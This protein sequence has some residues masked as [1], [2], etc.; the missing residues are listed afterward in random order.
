M[1]RCPRRVHF[2]RFHRMEQPGQSG[3]V[4]VGAGEATVVIGLRQRDPS[5][6]PLIGQSER[7]KAEWYV[8]DLGVDPEPLLTLS[9]TELAE[10]PPKPPAEQVLAS[11]R[12]L[13]RLVDL[14]SGTVRAKLEFAGDDRLTG[15]ALS[16]SGG[17]IA[18]GTFH[19]R[20]RVWDSVSARNLLGGPPLRPRFEA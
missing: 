13:L 9:P 2:S 4:H 6:A 17:R 14:T 10:R 16:P 11:L 18:A 5:F 12:G 20:L 15:V 3:P 8:Y 1:G 19:S 7:N